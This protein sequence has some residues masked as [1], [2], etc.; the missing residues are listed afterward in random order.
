MYK[1]HRSDIIAVYSGPPHRMLTLGQTHSIK[2]YDLQVT[3]IFVA[4]VICAKY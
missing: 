2:E 1:L 3:Y 4:T